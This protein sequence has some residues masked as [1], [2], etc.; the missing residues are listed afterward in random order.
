[1]TLNNEQLRREV[2][3]LK[4]ENDMVKVDNTQLRANNDAMKDEIT[5]LKAK[6]KDEIGPLTT[7]LVRWLLI[8]K[9]KY[10]K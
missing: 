9:I 10:N 7:L 8:M 6:Q 4:T 3:L 5:Q 2:D 1:M